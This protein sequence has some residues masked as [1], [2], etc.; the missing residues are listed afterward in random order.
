MF[1]GSIPGPSTNDPE[2]VV[3]THVA[4]SPSSK[5][6]YGT[7][8]KLGAKKATPCHTLVCGLAASASVWLKGYGNG[9]QR[10]PMW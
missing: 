1:S 9:D 4:L 3:H 5:N 8:C 10:R 7:G 2:Q 6:W